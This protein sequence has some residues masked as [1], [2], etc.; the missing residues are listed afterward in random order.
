MANAPENDLSTPDLN[1]VWRA[2]AEALA[3]EDNN[4]L[5]N[6]LGLTQEAFAEV[7]ASWE[8]FRNAVLAARRS[9][10]P[11]A[12]VE[13]LDEE[14]K[15]QW[16]DLTDL[17]NLPAQQRAQLAVSKGGEV[18][19]QRMFV[20]AL[21]QT[22]FH[23]AKCLKILNISKRTYDRWLR[24]SPEFKDMVAEINW[25]KA[26]FAEEALFKLI[27]DGSEKATIMAVQTLSKGEY[28]PELAIKGEVV[29]TPGTLDL[30]SLNLPLDLE[31]KLLEHIASQ[32]VLDSDGALIEGS[33]VQD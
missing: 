29:H 26:A 3:T 25:K 14:T 16:K 2:Y 19:R 12:L 31:L 27:E 33:V 1:L 8:P 28:G 22:N 7:Y 10:V 15:Q 13:W 6:A 30:A 18:A 21:L 23:F 24:E 32:G 17:D 5:S 4:T 9:R 11:T 20:Y